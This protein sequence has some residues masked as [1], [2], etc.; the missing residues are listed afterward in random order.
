MGDHIIKSD[1][2]N[3]M[4]R[5]QKK[6]LQGLL[7]LRGE[8]Y[9]PSAELCKEFGIRKRYLAAGLILQ[10]KGNISIAELARR[11]S[12]SRTT[13]YEWPEIVRALKTS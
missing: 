9:N 11:L 10:E 3:G 12:V 7:R 2:L 8:M 1:V 4:I 13:I 5:R 6:Q